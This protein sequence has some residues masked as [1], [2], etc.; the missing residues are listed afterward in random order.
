VAGR[1]R[2]HGDGVEAVELF[3][4]HRSDIRCVITDLTMPRMDGWETL[5]ALGRAVQGR[6]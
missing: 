3:Q 6:G 1:I 4:R 5:A 2:L